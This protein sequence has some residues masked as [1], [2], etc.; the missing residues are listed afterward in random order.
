MR[1]CF[2]ILQLRFAFHC[3]LRS[4][5]ACEPSSPSLPRPSH[6][7]IFHVQR[8]SRLFSASIARVPARLM[9]ESGL[10][11]DTP[12]HQALQLPTTNTKQTNTREDHLPLMAINIA[13]LQMHTSSL[14]RQQNCPVMGTLHAVY[15]LCVSCC[16]LCKYAMPSDR[17]TLRT[18]EQAP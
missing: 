17:A 12:C 15:V 8:R 9:L 16:L 3:C 10:A 13:A 6:S 2:P 5:C 4:C 7:I 11:L 18:Q 14:R 1:L